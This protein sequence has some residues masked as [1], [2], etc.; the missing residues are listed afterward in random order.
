MR[1]AAARK[2]HECKKCHDDIWPGDDYYPQRREKAICFNCGVKST[3][4]V[5]TLIGKLFNWLGNHGE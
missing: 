1:L 2:L 5:K 3:K 4:K